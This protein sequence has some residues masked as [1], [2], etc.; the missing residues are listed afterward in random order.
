MPYKRNKST[1]G[2]SMS[3]IGNIHI[4]E[5]FVENVFYCNHVDGVCAVAVKV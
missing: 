3:S 4:G 1:L 5:Q 2:Q